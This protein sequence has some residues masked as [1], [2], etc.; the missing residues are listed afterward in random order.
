MQEIRFYLRLSP[1]A[2]Q[3]YYRGAARSVTVTAEDGRLIQFP[4]ERL[5][6]FYSHGG[7]Q[8]RFLLR[9]DDQN[10]FQELVRIGP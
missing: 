2:Y 6:P 7:V 10:R 9:I 8:G 4:A 3:A 1:E 5:R